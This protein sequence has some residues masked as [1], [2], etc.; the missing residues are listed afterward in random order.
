MRKICSKISLVPVSYTHLDV[1][2]R[3]IK[4]SAQSREVFAAG[5]VKAGAF[6]AGCANP[7]IYN[8]DDLVAKFVNL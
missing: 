5:A 4:H 8:M 3:Q 2:K 7:G 6:L 1:Y